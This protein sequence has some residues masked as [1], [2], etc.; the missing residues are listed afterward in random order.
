[1]KRKKKTLLCVK[2]KLGERGGER[3]KKKE[4]KKDKKKK[5]TRGWSAQE[6]FDFVFLAILFLGRKSSWG[7]SAEGTARS[8]DHPRPTQG[9]KFSW[10]WPLAPS[11]EGARIKAQRSQEKLKSETVRGGGRGH[12]R[13]PEERGGGT[14]QGCSEHPAL[15]IPIPGLYRLQ[16]AAR[17]DWEIED[18]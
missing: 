8:Q 13:P 6:T 15:H 16:D 1:M 18:K 10:Q 14:P 7:C 5:T 9:P 4:K 3:G 11:T 17:G 2:A 12:R